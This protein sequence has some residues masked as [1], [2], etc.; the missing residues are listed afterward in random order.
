MRNFAAM[1]CKISQQFPLSLIPP[2]PCHG[3][4]IK[5][6]LWWKGNKTKS[7]LDLE[8]SGDCARYPFSCC[9]TS[10]LQI[11]KLRLHLH[12]IQKLRYG[13]PVP[14]RSQCHIL[15]V[16]NKVMLLPL[17]DSWEFG[18][19]KFESQTHILDLAAELRHHLPLWSGFPVPTSFSF[20][21]SHFY[22][23]SYSSGQDKSLRRCEIFLLRKLS[24]RYEISQINKW[25]A[26]TTSFYCDWSLRF[27][28]AHFY[29]GYKFFR[30]L[31]CRIKDFFIIRAIKIWKTIQKAP[32]I[33]WRR[34]QNQFVAVLEDNTVMEENTALMEK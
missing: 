5:Y 20:P 17:E 10:I 12:I 30:L 7:I 22:K 15:N 27:C 6:I 21:I 18:K 26:N 34:D 4:C 25:R 9:R 11:N 19:D 29:Q 23:V 1:Q 16:K 3:K 14:S 31:I 33:I 8:N 2:S 24:I 13:A 32:F 28:V